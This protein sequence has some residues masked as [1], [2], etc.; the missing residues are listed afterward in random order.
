MEEVTSYF[1]EFAPNS[2][3]WF[4]CH[5]RFV[6]KSFEDV[7]LCESCKNLT[8]L[9]QVNNMKR[10]YRQ[11]GDNGWRK[12]ILPEVE[13]FYEEKDNVPINTIYSIVDSELL[14]V[15]EMNLSLNESA[16]F[17][18]FEVVDGEPYCKPIRSKTGPRESFEEL[19]STDCEEKR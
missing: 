12:T 17:K 5:C 13:N 10:K 9:H 2:F 3:L 7:L 4:K 1:L 6:A 15:S 8:V 18:K 19:Y 14:T 16:F 11:V